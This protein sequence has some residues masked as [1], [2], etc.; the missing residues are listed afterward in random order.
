[1]AHFFGLPSSSSSTTASITTTLGF[2]THHGWL[3]AKKFGFYGHRIYFPFFIRDDWSF[4]L[5]D[6][7]VTATLTLRS[8]VSENFLIALRTAHSCYPSSTPCRQETY[9]A[10]DP[11]SADCWTTGVVTSP[12]SRG[13]LFAAKRIVFRPLVGYILI[14]YPQLLHTIPQETSLPRASV[15]SG[16]LLSGHSL[17]CTGFSQ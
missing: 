12:V 16:V 5:F 10:G 15:D 17:G 2:H 3:F 8:F 9:R 4:F 7:W 6:C 14:P 1:M 11:T 13:P